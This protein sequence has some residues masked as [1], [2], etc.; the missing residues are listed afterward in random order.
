M[1]R[2]GLLAAALAAVALPGVGSSA[3][4]LRGVDA[5]GYPT[6]RLTV[7]TSPHSARGP[8]LRENGV[9]VVGLVA[10]NLGRD[11]SVVLAV[12]RSRS[13]AGASLG[14]AIGAARAFVAA[15]RPADRIALVAFGSR[16]VELARFSSATIDADT[17]LRAVAVDGRQGT[18]L[19]DA[20]VLAARSFA[21]DDDRGRVI[22]LLTDGRDVSSS[23]TLA[24]AIAAARAAGAAVYPIGI[25]GPQFWP[26]ALQRLALATGGAYHRAGSSRALAEIYASIARELERTWRLEY[27]TAARPGERLRISASVAGARTAYGELAVPGAAGAARIGRPEPSHLLPRWLY[28]SGL[29]SLLVALVVTG[30]V[31]LGGRL[32]LAAPKGSWLKGRLAAHTADV[33]SGAGRKSQGERLAA[34]AGLFRAT[35]RAFGQFGLWRKLGRL[36]ERADAPLRTVEFVYLA[37]GS[38]LLLGLIAAVGGRAPLVILFALALGAFVPYLVV[39]IKAARRTRSFE[40]QLP[41]LLITLAASLKAGHS[42][43]QGIQTVVDE[44]QE[45][46]SKEFKRVLAE[47][48]LGRP[49][50]D[51]LAKMSERLGSENFTF[52]IIAVTIQRQVGGSLAGLFDIVADTVRQRQQ[53]ARKLRALTAMG[54]MSAYVLVGMPFLLAIAITALNASYMAPLYETSTGHKL[55]LSG[56]VMMLFGSLI[57]K[58]IVSFRG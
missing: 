10:E 8:V 55:I 30:L 4:Q 53:F 1:K 58:K 13:M 56:L 37:G 50:D 20:I 6:V 25:D 21:G 14:D 34:A 35:E 9:P 22:I 2:R 5:S 19:Y 45:P 49:M 28:R 27:V 48:R 15:K 41:D 12:D 31:F 47:T 33:R 11:K 7:V 32:L 18:A 46:A 23:A 54:R 36:L 17:A 40:E 57:L 44:G 51:A 43:R 3:I 16:A 26:A 38:A 24:Q 52:V 39:L 42:F 29:G